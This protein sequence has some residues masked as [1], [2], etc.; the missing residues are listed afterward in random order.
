M[1]DA[2]RIGFIGTGLIGTPMVERLL[3]RG[4]LVTVWNRTADKAVP[5]VALGATLAMSARDLAEHVDIICLCLTNT[6]AVEDVVFGVPAISTVLPAAH[7]VA[8]S[9]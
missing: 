3:E 7:L 2:P 5:L 1:P 6:G 9:S 4:L 8:D